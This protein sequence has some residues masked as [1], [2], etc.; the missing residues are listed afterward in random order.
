MATTTPLAIRRVP[1]SALHPDPANA[2]A[3]NAANLDAIKASLTRFGQAEPLVVQAGSLR[4]I[5]GHGR[6]SAMQA[7]GWTEADIVEL[8]VENLDATALGIALNR[9]AELADWDEPVLAKLLEQLRAEDALDGVGF[10]SKDLD[11]LLD[12]LLAASGGPEG[13]ADAVPPLPAVATTRRG[14]LWV[15][16]NHRLYCADSASPA[17]VD[18]LLAGAPIHLVNSDPPYNVKV[19]PR[20]NNAIAAGLSSFETTHHQK[21]D[22]ARHPAKA[23]AT[24]RQMRAKD[25]PLVNDFVTD[26]SFDDLLAAWFG[27][28]ARVLLPGRAFYLWGGYSNCGNYPPALKAAGLYFSQA[29]IWDKQHPVLT[30]KDYMGAHEWCFYG[31]REGAAHQ[32]FGPNNATDLWSVK[33]VN[34]QSMVHLTETRDD[35]RPSAHVCRLP[36]REVRRRLAARKGG[37]PTRQRGIDARL[38]RPSQRPAGGG[39]RRG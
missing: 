36:A 10:S 1:L 30:R 27:N 22:L 32:F 14:D 2:R 35:P 16:G 20:S 24:H 13:D 15:L 5:A 28:F 21:L 7:L 31:W 37:A 26:E 34:P 11:G 38:P 25:R 6:L 12:E 17:D 23:Q 29:I 3:H 8:P 4:L 39:T 33:K 18:R 9:T 19:E